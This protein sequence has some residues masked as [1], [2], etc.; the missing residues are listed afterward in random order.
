M[1]GLV[2]LSALIIALVIGV[3]SLIHKV[4]VLDRFAQQLIVKASDLGTD[5]S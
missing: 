2:L 5:Y 3:S 1:L 4:T